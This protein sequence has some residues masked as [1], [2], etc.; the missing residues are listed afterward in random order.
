MNNKQ[1]QARGKLRF[2]FA[3]A[4]GTLTRGR[5]C[6]MCQRSATHRHENGAPMCERHHE[7]AAQ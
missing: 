6:C 5:M 4:M 1:R 3:V 2:E 7:R